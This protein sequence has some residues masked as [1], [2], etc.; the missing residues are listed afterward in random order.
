MVEGPRTLASRRRWCLQ[1]V[2]A[3]AGRRLAMAA[4]ATRASSRAHR[5][6]TL[7]VV[8]KFDLCLREIP[9]EACLPT[10]APEIPRGTLVMGVPRP[11]GLSHT[12][13]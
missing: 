11:V 3:T 7:N 6:P 2:A 1:V 9:P 12:S 13:S 10:I 4:I 8:D 5:A